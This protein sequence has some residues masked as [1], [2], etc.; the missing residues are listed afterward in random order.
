MVPGQALDA[1][2]CVTVALWNSPDY[3]AALADLGIARGEMIKAGEIANPSLSLLFPSDL[4]A[5]ELAAKLPLEALWLRPKRQQIARTELDAVAARL[6][7]AGTDLA[8]DVR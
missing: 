2:Q 8:R 1:E 7:Q 5:F 6:T 3:A 4:K